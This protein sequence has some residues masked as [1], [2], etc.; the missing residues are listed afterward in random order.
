MT[1]LVQGRDPPDVARAVTEC[2]RAGQQQARILA[3]QHQLF[4]DA[5][6]RATRRALLRALRQR[7]GVDA[8]ALLDEDFLAVADRPT[9]Y[10]AILDAA[11]TAGRAACADLQLCDRRAEV[12]RIAAQHGFTS[13]F[14]V[15]F[16]AVDAAAPTACATALATRQPVVVNDI[17]RSAIFTDQPTVELLL[18]AGSRA[19]TS[20]PLLF[21][22]GEVL[23]VL[24]FH[25]R[26]PGP[27]WG[28]AQLVARSAAQALTQ[29]P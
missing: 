23:G 20:Y 24:S 13:Q 7:G 5:E 17:T 4:I 12:L 21:A 11:V 3:E 14:V 15:F 16:A 25:H 18:K 1:G 27:N 9:V 26:T 19:V 6:V 10:R 8:A 28:A 22:N 29:L 2:R